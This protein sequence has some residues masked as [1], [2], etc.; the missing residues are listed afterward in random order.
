[1]IS[2]WTHIEIE[3]KGPGRENREK[4]EKLYFFLAEI[5]QEN[6]LS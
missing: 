3:I 6:Q 5:N 1:M 2:F 4:T